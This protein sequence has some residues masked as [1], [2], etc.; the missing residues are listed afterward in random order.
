MGYFRLQNG[1]VNLGW[2]VLSEIR[3]LSTGKI[4]P[5]TEHLGQNVDVIRD[6]ISAVHCTLMIL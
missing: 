1:Y 5:R 6:V 4:I 2:V 3:I